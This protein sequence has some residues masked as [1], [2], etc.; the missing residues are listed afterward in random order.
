MEARC[1]FRFVS[2]LTA[3]TAL[4]IALAG[5]DAV[6]HTFSDPR[7]DFS[8][9]V[10]PK[11]E[12]QICVAIPRGL[13]DPRACADIDLAPIRNY[14]VDGVA[15]VGFAY[16][17]DVDRVFM[18]IVIHEDG[19]TPSRDEF[20]QIARNLER[21]YADSLP[22]GASF[23]ADPHRVREVNGLTVI[24]S[25]GVIKYP[26]GSDEALIID[27]MRAAYV[28][29]D[30]GGYAVMVAGIQGTDGR[31]DALFE[32]TVATIKAKKPNIASS[33]LTKGLSKIGF[34]LVPFIAI[35]VIVALVGVVVVIRNRKKNQVTP[36]NW[37]SVPNVPPHAPPPPGYGYGPPPPR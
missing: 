18:V 20:D 1:S 15:P 3:L 27:H 14:Q 29:V 21:G 24:D 16:V 10:K 4:A 28:P 32:D 9:E 19:E 13:D 35:S 2:V 7:Q 30:D 37:V 25:G 36:V 26:K 34:L 31:F 17:H 11:G 23:R 5:R 6:A 33:R 12:E 8:V 22:P